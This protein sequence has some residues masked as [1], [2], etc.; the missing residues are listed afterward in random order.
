M[1]SM[2]RCWML[3]SWQWWSKERAVTSTSSGDTVSIYGVMLSG[4]QGIAV[5]APNFGVEILYIGKE[6][7]VS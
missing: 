7:G 4:S 3:Y 1:T 2:Y 5:G 6:E